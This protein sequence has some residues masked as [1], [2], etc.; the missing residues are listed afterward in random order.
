MIHLVSV[1]VQYQQMLTRV[2]EGDSH[3]W[4]AHRARVIRV[5]VLVDGL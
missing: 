3:L 4:R 5:V 2:L 1:Q